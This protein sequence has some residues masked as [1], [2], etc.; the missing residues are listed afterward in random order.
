M[1]RKVVDRA[2]AITEVMTAQLG[3]IG[4]A[5]EGCDLLVFSGV[6]SSAAAARSVAEKLGVRPLCV[7]FCPLFLPS[8]YHR[9]HE[10]PDRPYPAEVTDNRA[11]WDLDIQT[12]NAMFSD[13]LNTRR[14]SIGLPPVNNVRDYVLTGHPWLAADPALA[15]WRRPTPLDVTQT[16]AW[17]L[18]DVRPLPPELV[19]FLE[20]GAPPVYVGFGSM[21]QR[22]LKD[23]ARTAVEAIRAQGRR[24]LVFRGWADVAPLDADENCFVVDE[25]NQAALFK[26]V[27]AVIH[28]GGAGTTT[29]AALAGAP[30][31][32]IP[33]IMDQHYWAGKVGDLGIGVRVA[34]PPT[35]DSLVA[36]LRAALASATRL[37][38]A[39][40]AGTIRTDGAALAARMLLDARWDSSR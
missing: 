38:A 15:P 13:V 27:A 40:V 31:I 28:H 20:A 33:Q 8:P 7:A 37:R 5:A 12:M 32:I 10:Y 30:Q 1:N 16:G 9:P 23:V 36:A 24:V 18:P 4:A 6:F 29:T 21:P 2:Q 22:T 14:A 39:D 11:L 3:A 17:L 25:V 34:T 19:A 26:R 35:P